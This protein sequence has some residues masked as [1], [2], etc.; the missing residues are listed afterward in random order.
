MITDFIHHA[1]L[2]KTVIRTQIQLTESQYERLKEVAALRSCSIAQ[3]VRRGVDRV[4]A[5]HGQDLAWARFWE[6]AGSLEAADGATNVAVEH[7][8]YLESVFADE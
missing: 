8:A 1:S 6:A 7:D 5:E 4:L 3:L 2:E